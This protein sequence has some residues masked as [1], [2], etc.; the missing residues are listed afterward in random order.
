MQLFKRRRKIDFIVGG[1][2]KGGTTAL[3]YYLRKHPQIGMAESKELHFFDN[4]GVFSNAKIRYSNYENRF[5][6]KSKKKIYGEATPIY[7]YWK[8][9]CDRIWEYNPNI[10]LIF[11]LRNPITRAFSHWNMEFDKNSDKETFSNAIRNESNRIKESLPLQH[12][13]YS[14][15]DRG[16]YSEQIKRYKRY[17]PDNQLMFIKY[18]EFNTN[19]EKILF[20]IFN[21]LGVNPNEFTFERKTVHKR[22]KHSHISKEDN[23][24][25]QSRFKYDIHKVE[26]ILGWNCSD[27]LE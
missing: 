6:F 25:L 19:Q 24:Y 15:I 11:I 23:E 9:S 12:R 13:V 26:E 27:W 10:K 20:D 7:I 2:Q 21:F 16:L 3:D 22:E 18:E 14:Y 4:E 5:D 1:T 17:F 8:P